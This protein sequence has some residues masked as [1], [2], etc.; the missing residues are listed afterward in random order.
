[1]SR[2]L[3][4]IPVVDLHRRA[5]L[6]KDVTLD[7]PAPDHMGTDVVGVPAGTPLQLELRV[8]STGEGIYVSGSVRAGLTGECVRCLDPIAQDIVVALEELFLY[9]EAAHRAIEEGD[10]EAAELPQTDGESIDLE[11]SIRDALV[12]AMPFQPLCRAD[13]PGLCSVCGAR[14]ADDPEHEH[15]IVDPR[16][17][18]LAALLQDPEEQP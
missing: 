13:C 16:F 12:T 14:L 2:S 3:F 6:G 9:P 11:D 15:R 18:A 10:E 4:V 5:G 7:I 17:S 1:M 8:E